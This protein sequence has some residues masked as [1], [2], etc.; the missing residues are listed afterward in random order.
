MLRQNERASSADSGRA[1]GPLIRPVVDPPAYE[2]VITAVTAFVGRLR[3]ATTARVADGPRPLLLVL[4]TLGVGGALAGA[5]WVGAQT[6][7]RDEHVRPPISVASPPLATLPLIGAN[8]STVTFVAPG[9]APNPSPGQSRNAA[10]PS[11]TS[12]PIATIAVHAAGAVVSPAVYN[13]AAGARV[14]DVIHAAGGLTVDADPD[15][16]NL[17]ARVG[18]GERVFVPKRGQPIPPVQ[19]GTNDGSIGAGASDALASSGSSNASKIVDLNTASVLE[20][21]SLPG[22]GPA[23]AAK[24][25]DFRT[26]VGRF[27]SVTQL[28]EVPG[29]GDAKLALLRA[30]VKV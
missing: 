3:R 15:A 20:L 1:G 27:R 2:S 19:A 25:I 6:S 22:I 5:F 24:I 14:D 18:D 10:A 26:R 13:L 29:I 28:L 9:S 7:R 17:A 12:S 23:T 11:A 4:T 8:S 21:D 16:I 30:R